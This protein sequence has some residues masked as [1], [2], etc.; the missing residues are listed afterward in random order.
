MAISAAA[1]LPMRVKLQPDGGLEA[2]PPH[3]YSMTRQLPPYNE[4]ICGSF[5]SAFCRAEYHNFSFS[6]SFG[7]RKTFTAARKGGSGKLAQKTLPKAPSPTRKI[8]FTEVENTL[9]IACL[10]A[11][12]IPL[13]YHKGR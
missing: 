12:S 8:E 3:M 1:C 11:F 10:A 4:Y 5:T 13:S 2:L 7:L 6:A 9:E